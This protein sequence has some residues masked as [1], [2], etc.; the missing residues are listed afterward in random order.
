MDYIQCKFIFDEPIPWREVMVTYL[1]EM[2]FESF[3]EPTEKELLAYI[4]KPNFDKTQFEELITIFPNQEFTTQTKEIKDENWNAQWESNFDPIIVDDECIVR[5]PFH[6]I[7]D[8]YKYDL[9]IN[10][11]MSFGTGHHQT[12]FLIL[13]HLKTMD[14][15]NKSVLDM[16]CGTGVLA[17]LAHKLQAKDIVAIDI[18]EWSYN[19]TK[20]NN[21]LNDCENIEVLLGGAEQLEEN[22]KFD[23][24]LANINRNILLKDFE[25]YNKSLNEKGKIIMSGFY[26]TDVSFI[27]KKAN[28]LGL[29]KTN[30]R[31][32]E[33]WA[34]VEFTK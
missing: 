9:I 1:C 2:P 20:E 14:I 32:K 25:V 29:V 8:N 15:K 21:V 18:D 5:A 4:P 26:T 3:E 16:G 23:V 34:M 10:P 33:G 27:E 31:Q 22:Q 19:N 30:E 13:G 7:K 24:I 17:I 28:E 6:D 11:Q 12:T